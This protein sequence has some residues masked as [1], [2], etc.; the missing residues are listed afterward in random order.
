MSEEESLFLQAMADVDPIRQDDTAVIKVAKDNSADVYG[1]RRRAAEEHVTDAIPYSDNV[2][3]TV[4]PFDIVGFKR[5]GVQEGVYRQLRLGKYRVDA[6]L[7]LHDH[8]VLQARQVLFEFIRQC[9]DYDLRC[10]K[11]LHGK[12]DRDPERKAIIKNH[13]LQWLEDTPSVLAYHSAPANQGGAGAVLVLLS[14]SEQ[15]KQRNR[16]K[17][18]QG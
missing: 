2:L 18:G 17:Y 7:D 8:S 1:V 12:G 10:V 14:K 13:T 5:P 4:G 3:A 9:V 15:A 11:V 6:R 16:D